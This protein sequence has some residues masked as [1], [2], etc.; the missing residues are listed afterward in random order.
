[1]I[2][3]IFCQIL[4]GSLPASFVYRDD[5]VSAFLDIRPINPGH[6]LVVPNQHAVHTHDVAESTADHLAPACT[7]APVA[8]CGR[9]GGYEPLRR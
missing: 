1:M 2:D 8:R 5:R 7:C 9:S 6:V 4:A 3:C